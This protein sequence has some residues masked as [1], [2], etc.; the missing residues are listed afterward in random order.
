MEEDLSV[1]RKKRV[2]LENDLKDR[3]YE[4]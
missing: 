1:E 2:A 4:L 3:D